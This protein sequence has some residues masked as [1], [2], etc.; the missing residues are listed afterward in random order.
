MTVIDSLLHGEFPERFN[1]SA[2]YEVAVPLIDAQH[3][4][5]FL[6]FKNLVL[7][8][9]NENTSNTGVQTL[10]FMSNYMDYHFKA[11]EAFWELDP[12]IY[13]EHRR[14]HYYFVRE[15]YQATGRVQNQ[16]DI[17][18]ELLQFLGSWLLDHVL[19]MD[20]HHFDILRAHGLL[21]DDGNL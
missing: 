18:E 19:G 1:W 4:K 11:E 16:K 10:E 13:A 20:R 3:K 2:D 7:A 14:A 21:G 5:L 15:V 6:I 17:T 8:C 12:E 9:K